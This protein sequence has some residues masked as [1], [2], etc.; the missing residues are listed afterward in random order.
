M[1]SQH[2]QHYGPRQDDFIQML[3]KSR[4]A[5]ALFDTVMKHIVQDED[6]QLGYKPN[7]SVIALKSFPVN[8]LVLAPVTTKI[9]ATVEGKTMP[10][11]N[12]PLGSL[13][14]NRYSQKVSFSLGPQIVI[15]KKMVKLQLQVSLA[16]FGSLS[17]QMILKKSTW[18]F[19]ST[20]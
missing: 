7:K 18:K 4:I 9:S 16:P 2:A 19:T 20:W 8:S 5:Q 3:I 11:S 1:I 10:H 15:F 6:V 17:I 13:V 14:T 12:L